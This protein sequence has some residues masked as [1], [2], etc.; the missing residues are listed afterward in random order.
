[1]LRFA[2]GDIVA[3]MSTT[4]T[5][6]TDPEIRKA[7]LEIVA[8]AFDNYKNHARFQETQRSWILAPYLGVA[9]LAGAAMLNR[10][11]DPAPLE[12]DGRAAI[13]AGLAALILTGLLVAL[14]IVKFNVAFHRHYSRAE[15][16]VEGIERLV[17]DDPALAPLLRLS[18][19]PTT[20][21]VNPRVRGVG[22]AAIHNYLMSSIIGIEAA[23][24]AAL[25]LPICWAGLLFVAATALTLA[26]LIAFRGMVAVSAPGETAG[27]G[28]PATR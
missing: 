5:S 23:A 17:A 19:L 21:G 28:R 12:P 7:A 1:M 3:P 11:L 2:A 14:A 13:V 9:G 10:V 26:A 27:Q 20:G 4:P 22:A 18:Q 16:L 15:M 25:L 24:I 6:G 8:R